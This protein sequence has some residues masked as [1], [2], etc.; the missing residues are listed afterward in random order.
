[1]K[2]QAQCTWMHEMLA[3]LDAEGVPGLYPWLQDD[4]H[5]RFAGYPAGR[6]R[7]NFAVAWASMATHVSA[8]KHELEQ[9]WE[10]G[11]DVICRGEV[12]Y[13]LDDGRTIRAPFANI[14]KLRDGLISEYLIYVD[15]SAVFGA[16]PA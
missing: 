4:V 2:S 8:L 16:A 6:G 15:A 10:L 11:D 1:M 7:E 12:S 9:T 13:L 5:F 14:F 3:A